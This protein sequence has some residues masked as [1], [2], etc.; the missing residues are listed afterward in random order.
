MSSLGNFVWGIADQLRGVY[1]PHQYGSVILP[2][3]ILRRLD[4]QL[5]GTRNEVRALAAVNDNPNVLAARIR[6]QYGLGFYN[7]S[8]YDLERLKF[9]PDGLRANLLDYISRF[10]ANIDVFERFKFENEIATL[11]EKN[12]LLLVVRQFA[13]IDLHP[14]PC[15]TRRWVT[16]SRS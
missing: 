7:T 15:P 2:M 13:E 10:S 3:T 16:C 9:D 11:A 6:Q 14:T 8:E 12:R 4:C 5:A 1:R